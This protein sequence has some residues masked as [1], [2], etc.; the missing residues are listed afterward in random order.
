GYLNTILPIELKSFEAFLIQGVV[1]I[2]WAT[3]TEYNNH[4]FVVERSRD[5]ITFDSLF[6]VEGA[7]YSKSILNYQTVDDRP[8]AGMSY[9]R[10]K[11]VDYDGRFT[12]SELVVIRNS[13]NEGTGVFVD[14]K[15][16]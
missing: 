4:Y 5:G 10:L 15:S 12:Y 11:Q 6:Y 3:F 13:N 9:Y 8:L 16:T 14:R 7:G 2:N 1:E